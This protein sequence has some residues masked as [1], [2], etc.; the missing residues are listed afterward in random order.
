MDSLYAAELERTS[1]AVTD[2]DATS[3]EVTGVA[4]GRTRLQGVRDEVHCNHASTDSQEGR[5]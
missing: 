5:L 2:E 1:P 4:H 3:L